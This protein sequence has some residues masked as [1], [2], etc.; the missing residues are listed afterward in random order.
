MGNNRSPET[1]HAKVKYGFFSYQGHTP[2]ILMQP[3]RKETT[4]ADINNVITGTP[5]SNSSP[6]FILFG[7]LFCT[8]YIKWHLLTDAWAR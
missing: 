7:M 1:H 8:V 2:V 4:Y 6:I 3:T 5:T